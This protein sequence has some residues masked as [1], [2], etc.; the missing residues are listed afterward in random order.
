MKAQQ[1]KSYTIVKG[2]TLSGIALQAYGQPRKWRDI[3][4]ANKN[5]LRSGDPN[6]IYPGEIIT[7]P[8]DMEEKKELD[9]LKKDSPQDLRID[10]SEIVRLIIDGNEESFISLRVTLSIDTVADAFSFVIDTDSN[11]E[12]GITPF[13]FNHVEVYID[14]NKVIDGFVYK[15]STAVTKDGSILNIS[16][17]N[18]TVDIIDSNSEPPYQYKNKTLKQISEELCG[19]FGINIIDNEN[20]SYKFKKVAIEKTE[21]IFGFINKLATQRGLLFAS[22]SDGDIEITK[23]DTESKSIGS[24]S[25]ES[26][27]V[28]GIECVFDGRARFSKYRSSGTGPGKNINAIE[29]DKNISRVRLT[30]SNADETTSDK[31]KDHNR[32]VKNKTIGK[33]ISIPYTSDGFYTDSDEL[34]DV[35]KIVTVED[36]KLF[37]SP[38]SRF[39][40][41]SVEYLIE[42]K[43]RTTNVELT[44][45]EVY[46]DE[47][48]KESWTVG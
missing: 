44:L 18:G 22:N 26:L 10:N 39:L 32:S 27:F 11:T 30:T 47:E 15:I 12:I 31:I 24:I 16:G 40:I 6:L 14:N 19:P 4:K 23:A 29:T 5:S 38:G 33:S 43:S 2:D 35:N 45:P 1:G 20:D 3:W 42:G 13:A 7:I 34:W 37:L 28:P 48:V 25:E 8:F 9:K 41:K 36:A 46:T 17:F 21:K